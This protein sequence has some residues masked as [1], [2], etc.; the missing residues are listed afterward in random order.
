MRA[1]KLHCHNLPSALCFWRASIAQTFTTGGNQTHRAVRNATAAVPVE[2][3]IDTRCNE[4][5]GRAAVQYKSSR[6]PKWREGERSEI[7]LCA[8]LG[9]G[10]PAHPVL[11]HPYRDQAPQRAC[12][13]GRPP[14]DAKNGRP[15]WRR[16]DRA[17]ASDTASI[18]CDS[19][20]PIDA[21]HSLHL[22][23]AMS[24]VDSRRKRIAPN[25]AI[26][27]GCFRKDIL[28]AQKRTR[29]STVL[30]PLGPEPSASTNSA[31]WATGSA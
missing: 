13:P 20:R 28:G 4:S 3:L 6:K 9:A 26:A 27:I 16:G 17:R 18:S 19:I 24:L 2:K 23:Y 22:R 7:N 14:L 5:D 30:P 11:A 12:K 25:Q 21:I 10:F 31:I 8:G 29:T 1:C 15:G